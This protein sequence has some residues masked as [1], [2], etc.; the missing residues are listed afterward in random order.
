MLAPKKTGAERPQ[1]G[2]KLSPS[3]SLSPVP[4]EGLRE[5]QKVEV[6]QKL[7]SSSTAQCLALC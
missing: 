1:L 2:L 4:S 5:S 3:C 7:C 6:R